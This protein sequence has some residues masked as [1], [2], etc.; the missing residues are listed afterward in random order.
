MSDVA[1]GN[2]GA[3]G[4]V[5]GGIP[6]AVGSSLTVHMRNETYVT[7]CFFGD[8]ATN[9]GSFHEALN[10]AAIWNLPIVF[11]CENNQYGMSS[12]VDQM[13]KIK[14]LSTRARAYG[15]PGDKIDG[16]DVVDVYN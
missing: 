10:M 14:Y 12:S 6:I 16:K 5:G 9:E 8:G 15:F 7:V 3:K 11:I 4:I 1:Q 13:V 2:L